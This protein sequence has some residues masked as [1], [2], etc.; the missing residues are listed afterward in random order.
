MVEKARTVIMLMDASKF[1]RS[2]PYTFATLPDVDVIVTSRFF[3]DEM[4]Q[5]AR[6]SGVKVI[7]TEDVSQYRY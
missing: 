5:Q 1:E 2:L 7:Y 6:E 3:P 4:M